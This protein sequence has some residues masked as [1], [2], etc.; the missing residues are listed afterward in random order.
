MMRLTRGEKMI[1]EPA[2][3]K[4]NSD[5]TSISFN[6]IRNEIIIPTTSISFQAKELAK[7]YGYL[8]YMVQ[9]YIDILG[10]EETKSLL[11][12]FENFKIRPTIICNF[13]R[14]SC[15]ELLQQLHKLNFRLEPISWCHHCYRVVDSPKQPSIGSTHQYLK[16]LYY[17]YRDAASTIPPLILNP[18]KG[19]SIIDM[20]A[21][22][23]GKAIHISLL[24]RDEGFFVLNDISM[25]RLKALISNYYRMGFKSY[26]ITN[27][28]AILLPNILNHKFDYVFLDAPCSAEGAIMFDPSRKRK[29]SQEDLVKLVIRELNLLLSALKLVKIGGR[30][31]YTTCSIA[32]EENEYVIS[33]VLS[34]ADSKVVV[35]TPPF[36]LWSNG[37][38]MFRNI[39]FVR[40]VEKCIRIWPHRHMME[41]F[42]VCLLRKIKED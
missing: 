5:Y 30:I 12:T 17:I 41:G 20:C 13:L 10:L 32:P 40:D 37:I 42:F 8:D 25:K 23:G 36:N 33:K 35:E 19:S 14:I 1:L 6:D 31:V 21:A 39:E 38:R 18:I 34:I 24:I 29:T 2:S 9:R 11:D 27:Y 4:Y 28:D 15:E 26:L 7:T 22:P 3:E 16:G